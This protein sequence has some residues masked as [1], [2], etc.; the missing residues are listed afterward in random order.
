V[1]GRPRVEHRQGRA[2]YARRAWPARPLTA[3]VPRAGGL[4]WPN[5]VV[6]PA[7]LRPEGRSTR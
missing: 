7:R 3:P 6:R 5:G 2:R 4:P 1:A